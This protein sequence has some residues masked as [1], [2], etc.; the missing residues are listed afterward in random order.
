[1]NLLVLIFLKNF[2]EGELSFRTLYKNC[3][4]NKFEFLC[5]KE[6]WRIGRTF[7]KI[8][9]M[10]FKISENLFTITIYQ[11]FKSRNN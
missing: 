3:L 6:F 9:V 10:P 5:L 11:A 7:E 2:W 1:M 4:R 8:V